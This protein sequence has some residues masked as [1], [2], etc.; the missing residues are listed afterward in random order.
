M[1]NYLESTLFYYVFSG[2]GEGF[3]FTSEFPQFAPPVSIVEKSIK[4]IHRRISTARHSSRVDTASTCTSVNPVWFIVST[5]FM[6][7][8]LTITVYCENR[9]FRDAGVKRCSLS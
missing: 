8:D 7:D 4:Y 2:K 9:G 1:Q 5:T 6:C 3:I